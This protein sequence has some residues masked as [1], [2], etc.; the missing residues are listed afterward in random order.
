MKK[1]SFAQTLVLILLAA[2]L[3]LAAKPTAPNG[4]AVVAYTNQTY[5]FEYNEQ[6]FATAQILNKIVDNQIRDCE[7]ETKCAF[8]V[9]VTITNNTFPQSNAQ[10]FKGRILQNKKGRDATFQLTQV[11]ETKQKTV[12]VYMPVSVCRDAYNSNTS[13]TENVCEFTNAFTNKTIN[14]EERRSLNADDLKPGRN[15]LIEFEFVR[16]KWSAV[17][18]QDL[19]FNLFGLEFDWLAW[20]DTDW[21]NKQEIWQGFTLSESA[22]VVL[23]INFSTTQ[24]VG[25]NVLSADLNASRFINASEDT[26]RTYYIENGTANTG[27]TTFWI[28]FTY[29]ANGNN[30]GYFYYN[31]NATTSDVEA[32]PYGGDTSVQIQNDMS[33]YSAGNPVNTFRTDSNMTCAAST[34]GIVAGIYG[35]AT[36]FSSGSFQ[37]SQGLALST[38]ITGNNTYTAEFVIRRNADFQAGGSGSYLAGWNDIGAGY[39]ATLTTTAATNATWLAWDGYDTADRYLFIEFADTRWHHLVLK[40]YGTTT[41]YTRE[42]WLD[43]TLVGSDTWN[44]YGATT[45][46]VRLFGGGTGSQRVSIDSFLWTNDNKSIGWIQAR[47]KGLINSTWNFYPEQSV[48]GTTP[49]VTFVSPTVNEG[50]WINASYSFINATVTNMAASDYCQITIRNNSGSF[51]INTSTVFLGGSTM[52]CYYN[53][54]NAVGNQTLNITGVATLLGNGTSGNLSYLLPYFRVRGFDEDTGSALGINVTITNGTDTR[55]DFQSNT[56][57]F[58]HGTI[59]SGTGTVTGAASGYSSR[60]LPYSFSTASNTTFGT[61][62]IYLTPSATAQNVL[63]VVLTAYGGTGVSG[64]TV[65][66]EK[67]IGASYVLIGSTTTD[68][69]GQAP[70]TLTSGDTYRVSASATGFTTVTS[71]IVITPVQNTY[72]IYFGQTISPPNFTSDLSGS[73]YWFN[74]IS[75]RISTNG[76]NIVFNVSALPTASMNFSCIYIYDSQGNLLFYANGTHNSTNTTAQYSFPFDVYAYPRNVTAYGCIQRSSP[77]A[78]F[79]VSTLWYVGNFTNTT[80]SLWAATQ[81]IVAAGT[82]ST[83][84]VFIFLMICAIVTAWVTKLSGNLET[85]GLVALGLLAIG[86]FTFGWPQLPPEIFYLT[87]VIGVSIMFLKWRGVF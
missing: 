17:A 58:F 83:T 13:K 65:T 21:F 26:S 31:N 55:T 74:P 25:R 53:Q 27:Y 11:V 63:F 68:S 22:Q 61:I 33:L 35:N 47:A 79:N 73:G 67:L 82:N 84:F 76:T 28:N 52:N 70:F 29:V 54:T 60:T 77:Y 87:G 38:Y 46:T 32:D 64:A 50:T 24:Y 7:S 6:Q 45:G 36:N 23:P 8:R 5:V 9:N 51:S 2:S 15:F 41:P 16:P 40:T 18:S 85:G 57:S 10:W 14:Y 48:S 20:W 3:V 4:V 69:A 81:T 42:V 66:V 44:G 59:P 56:T 86:V 12:P 72:Y 80:S 71:S 49:V 43:G 62:D 1:K 34:P 39:A 75:S 30:T 19:T 78:Y 37:C